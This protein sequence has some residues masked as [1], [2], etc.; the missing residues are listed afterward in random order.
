MPHDFLRDLLPGVF[1]SAGA[2][3]WLRGGWRRLLGMFVLG[4]VFAHY[5]GTWLAEWAGVSVAATGLIV[6]FF[7]MA[8][9][10]RIFHAITHFDFHDLANRVI[11]KFLGVRK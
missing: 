1:G 4:V 6:G 5:L 2:L 3:F 11:D 7:S 8:L 10:D 9:A